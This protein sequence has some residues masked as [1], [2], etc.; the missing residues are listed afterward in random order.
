MSR[1]KKL[2]YQ[3]D[4]LRA[5]ADR[6][7]D[8]ALELSHTADRLRGSLLVLAD[9]TRIQDAQKFAQ[10]GAAAYEISRILTAAAAMKEDA[11]EI[12]NTLQER[13]AAAQADQPQT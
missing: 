1:S 13:V 2:P 6:A 10:L 12:A 5:A 4:E 9:I 11:A 8:D 7:Q 3:R